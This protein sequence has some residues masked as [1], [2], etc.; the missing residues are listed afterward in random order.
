MDGN[1]C[2][3]QDGAKKN[4]FYDSELK[5]IS[6]AKAKNRGSHDDGRE[7]K[8]FSTSIF[9]MGTNDS[10]GFAKDGEGPIREV[11][12]R[13]F[14]IDLCAV[15]NEDF[16]C[17]IEE[18]A[19]VTEA[20]QF[21]W[22]FVF[23][24]HVKKILIK[25][26]M[27]RTVPGLPWWYAVDRACWKRPEGPGSNIRKRLSYPVTHISYH[28]A[29]AYCTWAGKRLPTEAEWEFAAR[30]GLDQCRYPWGNELMP[31][32][33]HFCNIWQGEFPERDLCL[34]GFSGPCPVKYFPA[35]G[36]GLFNMSGNIWDWCS[37]LFSYDFHPEASINNPSGP[38][39]GE[40]RVMRGG[41]FLC[42]QSYCNRY[43]VAARTSNSPDSSTANLGFRCAR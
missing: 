33:K 28:D 36:Y 20:E 14:S 15:S 23:K 6:S 37:D 29:L 32:G 21:G 17:F 34:D 35:N 26:K 24:N 5:K 4:S 25:K 27:V 12:L 7:M 38:L 19:Y 10:E 43:R 2:I 22:S 30:G 8:N 16:E 9:Q 11:T 13:G 41:S 3:P 39:E 31:G 40:N 1:C 42:H 18:T